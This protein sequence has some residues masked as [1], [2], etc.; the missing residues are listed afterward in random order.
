MN[1]LSFTPKNRETQKYRTYR[2]KA[3]CEYFVSFVVGTIQAEDFPLIF[4]REGFL[5]IRYASASLRQAKE[6]FAMRKMVK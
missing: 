6:S 4:A 1:Q 3:K 2:R 5:H